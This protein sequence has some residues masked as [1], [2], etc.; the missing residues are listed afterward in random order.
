MSTSGIKKNI[1]VDSES[2]KLP[3]MPKGT[4]VWLIE[5][6]AL[7]FEQI[8]DF[9]GLHVLEVQALADD[10]VAS[11]MQGVDPVNLGQL[12]QEEI[13]R[14]QKDPAA[15]LVLKKSN[16]PQVKT[17]SKRKYT[18]LA[19]RRDRPDA[20]AWI[21][22]YYPDMTDVKICELVATTR[23]TVASIRNRT[24][25]KMADLRPRDPVLL[26]LCSQV[27]LDQAILEI[28]KAETNET[29]E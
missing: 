3:I 14:C 20:I 4:A 5:N 9:C 27:E 26:G 24:Y 28:K 25:A 21:I 16:I 10:Q 15:R 2:P 1:I 22:K 6:T 11:G 29:G 13:E 23:N 12:T 7:T 17:K 18:P 19:K 8:A